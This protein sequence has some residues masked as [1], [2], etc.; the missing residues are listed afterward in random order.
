MSEILKNLNS[1]KSDKHKIF[2]EKLVRSKY[3]I[4]GVKTPLLRKFAKDLSKNLSE[5]ELLN[6][7]KFED[8]IFEMILLKGFILANL[9]C[10]FSKKLEI[11]NNYIKKADNWALIDSVKF[12]KI[13]EYLLFNEI[14]L[15]LKSSDEFVL[16]AGFVNLLY[17]FVKDEYLDF[18]F[19]TRNSQG[20]YAQMAKAWLICECAIKFPNE[21]LSFLKSKN[22]SDEI[23]KMS[24]SKI[25]D[26]FR[27]S[28]NF[29]DEISKIVY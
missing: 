22:L 14:N 23:F 8:E 3:E 13:D 2:M 15:W 4:L 25:K 16:R 19:K 29:K 27:I 18:I 6:F 24:K 21:T 5:F 7:I 11:Y 1:L 12:K 26:S 28:N 17:Y 20:Y 10:E 9:K